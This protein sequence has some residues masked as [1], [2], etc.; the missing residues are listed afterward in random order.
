[1]AKARIVPV[2]RAG[3]ELA[4][5]MVIT[6]PFRSRE[7]ANTYLERMKPSGAKVHDST[8]LINSSRRPGTS[9]QKRT[10]ENKP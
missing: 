3:H 7:R 6:G 2:Y 5:F 9:R 8:S 10:Q 4:E 1:L